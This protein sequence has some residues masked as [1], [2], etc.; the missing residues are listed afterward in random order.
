M[1]DRTNEVLAAVKASE[2]KLLDAI[3]GS[4]Q[5]TDTLHQVVEPE[6]RWLREKL[7]WVV[8]VFKRMG[9]NRTGGQDNL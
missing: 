8:D 3:E 5:Q 9:R 6:L 4:R 7:N 2:K 1:T